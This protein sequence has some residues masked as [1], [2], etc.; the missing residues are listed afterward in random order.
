MEAKP[1]RYVFTHVPKAEGM[2]FA[3]ASVEVDLAYLCLAAAVAAND[4]I[5]HAKA[6]LVAAY[7]RA[8]RFSN[9]KH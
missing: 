7:E 5:E 8:R 6:E 1:E 4:G 3:E 2:S 9:Y